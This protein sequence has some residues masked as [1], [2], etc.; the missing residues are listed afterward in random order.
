MANKKFSDFTTKTDS[1]NV[2]FL[3]GIKDSDNV[4]IAPSNIGG[5]DTARFNHNFSHGSN[6][7]SLSYYLPCNSTAESSG[8][9]TNETSG[10]VG[11]NN[12]YVS[13]VRMQV[14]DTSGI[15]SSLFATQTRLIIQ[16]NGS[17]VHTTAYNNHGTLSLH[18]SIEFNFS[19]TDAPFNEGQQVS[20][21]FQADGLWYRTNAMTEH[22]YT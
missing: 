18:D 12:G 13:K 2:D 8:A 20:V 15:S 16:V 6:S 4:K 22:T 3:V 10:I 21:R 19:A 7:P 11:L 1:G 9:A 17:T 5:A 14:V